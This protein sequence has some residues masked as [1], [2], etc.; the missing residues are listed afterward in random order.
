MRSEKKA[1]LEILKNFIETDKYL[2][3]EQLSAKN[4]IK[5]TT[6][7]QYLGYTTDIFS[8]IG[9]KIFNVRRKGG[10]KEW[11]IEKN[12]REHLKILLQV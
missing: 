7:S 11:Q 2:S 10:I 3:R 4:N 9:V 1:S 5:P 6:V 8:E 12:I